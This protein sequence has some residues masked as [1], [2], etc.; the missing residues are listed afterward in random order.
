VRLYHH[1]MSLSGADSTHAVQLWIHVT[2]IAYYIGDPNFVDQVRS[3]TNIHKYYGVTCFLVVGGSMRWLVF[4]GFNGFLLTCL[5]FV[6]Q[7]L[8]IV[9]GLR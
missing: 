9:L 1:F 2:A 6:T 5:L 3:L 7:V 8:W 4:M